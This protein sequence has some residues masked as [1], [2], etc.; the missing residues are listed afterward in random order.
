MRTVYTIIICLILWCTVA[1]SDEWDLKP[2]I[3]NTEF[4]FGNSRI[5]LHYD[6]TNYVPIPEYTLLIFKNEKNIAIYKDLGFKQLFASA[7]NKYF[8]GVSNSGL[9]KYAY[10][11]LIMKE[12]S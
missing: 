10:I 9:V 6:S 3:K 5:V 4:I 2:E 12:I 7:D 1:F 11:I 8:L